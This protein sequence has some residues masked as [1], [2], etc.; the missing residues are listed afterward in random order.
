MSEDY[1]PFVKEELARQEKLFK[2]VNSRSLGYGEMG[3]ED[4]GL[5]A[6]LFGGTPV[7]GFGPRLKVTVRAIFLFFKLSARDFYTRM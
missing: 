1:C 4:P 2:G 5:A 6:L 3:S 7:N